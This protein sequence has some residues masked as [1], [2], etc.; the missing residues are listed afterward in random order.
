M[1]SST[2]SV[3]GAGSATAALVPR[4]SAAMKRRIASGSSSSAL[5]LRDQHELVVGGHAELVDRESP[6][7]AA[8]AQ[9]QVDALDVAEA[10]EHRVG[11]GR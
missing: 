3:A 10:A 9:P 1:A 6:S 4:A 8:A 2:A 7:G 11:A 5:A